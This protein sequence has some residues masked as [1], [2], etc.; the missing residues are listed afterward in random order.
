MLTNYRII[1]RNKKSSTCFTIFVEEKLKIFEKYS[2]LNRLKRVVAYC[3]SFILNSKPR[4]G[5]MKNVLRTRG[6]LAVQELEVSMQ[7]IIRLAQRDIF[8]SEIADLTTTIPFCLF[9]DQ[10]KVI[11]VGGRLLNSNLSYDEK[12]PYY[13]TQAASPH[14]HDHSRSSFKTLLF[15][16]TGTTSSH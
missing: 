13:F 14:R 11:R 9:L 8:E 15:G 5:E 10:N 1:K 4:K 6:P 16:S 7:I 12:T 3:K 2:P